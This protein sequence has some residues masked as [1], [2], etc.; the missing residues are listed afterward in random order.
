MMLDLSEGPAVA[1]VEGGDEAAWTA[2]GGQLPQEHATQFKRFPKHLQ[3]R[4]LRHGRDWALLV[5]RPLA[6]Y[7][8]LVPLGQGSG[9]LREEAQR[10]AEREGWELREAGG[11]APGHT[12]YYRQTTGFTCGPATLGMA[13]S[14]LTGC[15]APDRALEIQ[16]WRE[17]TTIHA[18]SGP[19]GCDPF[20]LALAAERRGLKA[21]VVKSRPGPQILDRGA[22]DA[23]RELMRFVQESFCAEAEAA[24]IASHY[25]PFDAAFLAAHVQAGGQAIL[26]VDQIHMHGE[27]CPHWILLTAWQAGR[28]HAHDPWLDEEQGESS[29]DVVDLP[30]PPAAVETIGSYGSPPYQAAVLLSRR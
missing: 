20:G 16:I 28:F 6:H 27:V 26:L 14:G 30:L 17:A 8:K 3:R 7:R 11:H 24:G 25:R 23:R 5:G 9:A 18:P 4:A 29:S 22:D 15:S 21:E 1:A 2:L 12:P 19:G 10:L 13:L